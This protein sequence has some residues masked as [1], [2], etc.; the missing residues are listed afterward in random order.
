MFRYLDYKVLVVLMNSVT[1]LLIVFA[2]WFVGLPL[3]S[4]LLFYYLCLLG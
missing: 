2:Y 3:V 1:W 4:M